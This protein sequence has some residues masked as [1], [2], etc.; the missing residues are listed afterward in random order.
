[1]LSRGLTES[2]V[3][4]KILE[5][6]WVKEEQDNTRFFVPEIVSNEFVE[7]L[8]RLDY[9]SD[10]I[11]NP[12]ILVTTGS[13]DPIHDGHVSMMSA[14]KKSAEES[15]Y[16][17]VSGI[18]SAGHDGYVR[19]RKTPEGVNGFKR[20]TMAEEFLKNHL[21]NKDGWLFHDNWEA[22]IAPEAVNFTTVIEWV[23]A[24]V[25]HHAP[26]LAKKLTLF[27]VFGADNATFSHSLIG[28]DDVKPII[29]QRKGYELSQEIANNIDK[30]LALFAENNEDVSSTVIRQQK[31]HT[32]PYVIRQ[33]LDHSLE[34]LKEVLGEAE[35][36]NRVSEFR[37]SLTSLFQKSIKNENVNVL[38]LNV[39]EQLL[40]TRELLSNNFRSDTAFLSADKY[41]EADN[42]VPVN[43]SR[44]FKPGAEQKYAE[45]ILI[46]EGVAIDKN[47]KYVFV[48]DD[49]ATGFTLEQLKKHYHIVDTVSMLKIMV[50]YGVYDVVDERD[51]LLGAENGGLMCETNT[52]YVR[53]PYV[54][55]YVNLNTRALIKTGKVKAMSADLWSMN[56]KF[57]ANTGI[58]VKDLK[59]NEFFYHIGIDSDTE[60]EAFCS[61]MH[62][63]L[64]GNVEE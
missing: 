28:F 6:G 7:M 32:R 33:D 20:C 14:A 38:T 46:K 30:S 31:L 5:A 63:L 43:C 52:G 48:D 41:L 8:K 62:V 1:M 61:Q 47:K 12:A 37:D 2:M 35:Y 22:L 60:I 10:S 15:G 57:Y 19:E 53:F 44:V 42:L 11:V 24:L 26:N 18:M 54:F 49:I 45:K 9:T 36:T 4:E 64:A 29:V 34:Y 56:E 51:F 25:H 16:R 58:R 55:P 40:K 23:K 3:D 50:P 27:Y 59:N 13:F 21:L 39:E 17:V